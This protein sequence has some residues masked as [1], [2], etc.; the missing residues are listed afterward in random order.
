MV[1]R[2]GNRAIPATHGYSICVCGLP[3][4]FGDLF[5]VAGDGY[6]ASQF[7]LY[8]ADHLPQPSIRVMTGGWIDD[9]QPALWRR[10]YVGRIEPLHALLI[11]AGI[12]D[13]VHAPPH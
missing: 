12:N 2:L 6:I 9:R 11:G 8:T 10:P 5:V 13:C 3:E 1:D 4:N 7:A